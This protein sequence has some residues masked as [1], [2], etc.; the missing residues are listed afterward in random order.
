MKI[1]EICARE[2]V[3]AAADTPVAAAAKL[4]RQYHVGDVIV[5]QNFGGRRI[6][7]GIVTDR[8]IVLGNL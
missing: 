5:T 6:P 8:D 7:S 1:G 4:M 2:V 3:C